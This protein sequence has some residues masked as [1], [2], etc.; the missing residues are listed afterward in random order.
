MKKIEFMEKGIL[1]KEDYIFEFDADF[2]CFQLMLLGNI[3]Y[4]EYLPSEYL[5][6]KRVSERKL[7][8]KNFIIELELQKYFSIATSIVFLITSQNSGNYY[9]W[10]RSQHPHPLC[11]IFALNILIENMASS[12][13]VPQMNND[14]FERWLTDCYRTI[15]FWGNA[16]LP[17][18]E[19]IKALDAKET[20]KLDDS[21]RNILNWINVD[22]QSPKHELD[23]LEKRKLAQS[24]FDSLLKV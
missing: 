23:K 21:V 6:I 20:V 8:Y 1:F 5:N 7:L 14:F 18:H 3:I 12:T 16:N 15:G 10:D 22:K 2:M 13:S 9:N 17:G 19:I 11:R 4:D 24:I